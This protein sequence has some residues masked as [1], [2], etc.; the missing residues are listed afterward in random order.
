MQIFVECSNIAIFVDSSENKG[1]IDLFPSEIVLP[2]YPN[3]TLIVA[4]QYLESKNLC[5]STDKIK[6]DR[7]SGRI[8]DIFLGEFEN[9][10][11]LDLLL[12]REKAFAFMI[13]PSNDTICYRNIIFGYNFTDPAIK[14]IILINFS[15]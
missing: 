3:I 15:V 7:D 9:L 6:S 8:L 10:D 4:Q 13:N 5:E 11:C 12:E 2:S 1:N 14:S